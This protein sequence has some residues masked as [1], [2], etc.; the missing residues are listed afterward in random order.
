MG[1]VSYVYPNVSDIPQRGSLLT[2]WQLATPL[3]CD[4][5]EMPGDLIKNKTETEKTGLRLGEFL[6]HAAIDVLYD[7]D[8]YLPPNLQYVIHTE[9]SLP[10]ND[11]YGISF[12]AP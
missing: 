3:S 12:Q 4:Y 2:R 1:H 11:G 10:R 8:D 7:N 6:T 9:P 5:I